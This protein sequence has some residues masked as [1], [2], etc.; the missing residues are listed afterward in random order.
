MAFLLL[1][2]LARDLAG[3]KIQTF[4]KAYCKHAKKG[5]TKGRGRVFTHLWVNWE[6]SKS[7]LVSSCQLSQ[8][9]GCTLRSQGCPRCCWH[10]CWCWDSQE[11]TQQSFQL[12]KE[13]RADA[14]RGTRGEQFSPRFNSAFPNPTALS[15]GVGKSTKS[16]FKTWTFKYRVSIKES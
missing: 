5:D 16:P 12:P 14:E 15:E 1:R 8:T 7:W 13:R 6:K 11:K 3:A 10:C 2:S 9:T 4:H